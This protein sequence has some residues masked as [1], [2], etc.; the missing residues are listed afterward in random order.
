MAAAKCVYST[1]GMKSQFGCCVATVSIAVT[2]SYI[3]G[4]YIELI[5]QELISV[6]CSLLL[7]QQVDRS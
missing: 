5:A 6:N 1:V 2:H 7:M 3:T 4:L